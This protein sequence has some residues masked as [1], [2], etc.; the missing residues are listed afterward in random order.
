MCETSK[1]RLLLQPLEFMNETLRFPTILRAQYGLMCVFSL[2]FSLLDRTRAQLAH[3]EFCL[4]I[5]P[6]CLPQCK[7][8]LSSMWMSSLDGVLLLDVC[9]AA[10]VYQGILLLFMQKEFCVFLHVL[11]F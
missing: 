10:R 1:A 11:A 6:L 3:S 8:L 2:L 9:R 7:F 5:L 4:H